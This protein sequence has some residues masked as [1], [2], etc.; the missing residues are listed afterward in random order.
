M[1]TK[2]ITLNELR[3]L[4]KEAVKKEIVKEGL[5]HKTE[6][7]DDFVEYAEE[8][9]YAVALFNKRNEL[10]EDYVDPSD[11]PSMMIMLSPTG[12]GGNVIAPLEYKGYRVDIHSGGLVDAEYIKKAEGFKSKYD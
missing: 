1:A 4:I 6:S 9:G 5:T 11:Y 7:I 10:V 3:N 2:K 12:S 8:G